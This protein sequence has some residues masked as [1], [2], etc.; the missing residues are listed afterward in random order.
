MQNG[1][2]AI[3]KPDKFVRFSNGLNKMAAK[4]IQK[5]DKKVSSSKTGRSGFWLFT[6]SGV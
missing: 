1:R 2:Q 3:Q 4:A 6:V 5:P